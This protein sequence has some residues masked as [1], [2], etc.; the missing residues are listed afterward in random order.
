MRLR[1]SS[2]EQTDGDVT[3]W[4]RNDSVNQIRGPCSLLDVVPI[5]EE[6][7]RILCAPQFSDGIAIEEEARHGHLIPINQTYLAVRETEDLLLY[8]KLQMANY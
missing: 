7:G 1:Y 8:W 4:R 2:I 5:H 6:G 3:T